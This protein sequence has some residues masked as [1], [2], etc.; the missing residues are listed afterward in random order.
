MYSKRLK[1]GVGG[2]LAVSTLAVGAGF[3]EARPSSEAVVA[4][5]AADP[6]TF[7]LPA[8]TDLGEPTTVAATLTRFVVQNGQL[9]AVLDIAEQT[10]TVPVT[11][12]DANAACQ[13]LD[14]TLGPIHLDLLGLVIDLDEVNLDIVAEP[15]AG[16]LL[17]NLL[18][19]VAGLFDDG[20]F[21]QVAQILNRILGLLNIS[22]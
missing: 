21:S 17:G 18:C 9:M 8:T 1:A 6:L 19:A 14:L 16:N 4:A 20:I 2:L 12:L 15:G 10:V 7:Q 22:I 5:R 11:E 3:V 13:I